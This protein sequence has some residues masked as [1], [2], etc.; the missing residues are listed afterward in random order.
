MS[1]TFYLELDYVLI[2]KIAVRCVLVAVSYSCLM[3]W[4]GIGSQ[5]RLTDSVTAE[6][7]YPIL[8]LT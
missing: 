6:L 4:M 1:K 3:P 7:S 8:C 5:S 2:E